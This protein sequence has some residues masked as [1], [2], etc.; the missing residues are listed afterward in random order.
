M[1]CT[2]CIK[3]SN[4]YNQRG[5]KIFGLFHDF[6][7]CFL[8]WYL[9]VKYRIFIILA[10]IT[11]TLAPAPLGIVILIFLIFDPYITNAYLEIMLA[12]G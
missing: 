9:N 6:L 4:D 3:A 2:T 1:L 11:S 7:K 5:F 8:K 12:T 10:A